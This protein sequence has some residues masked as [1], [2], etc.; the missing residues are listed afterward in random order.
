MEILDWI[1]YSFDWKED[2]NAESDY[3]PHSGI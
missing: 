2:S 3:D 1:L